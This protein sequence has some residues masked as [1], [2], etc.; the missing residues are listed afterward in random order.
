MKMHLIVPS[1]CSLQPSSPSFAVCTSTTIVCVCVEIKT[2]PRQTY[3]LCV[4]STSP[5]VIVQSTET[6]F[7]QPE[8]IPKTQWSVWAFSQA[9]SL[10]ASPD[11][12]GL[13]Q[14]LNS[15]W[16]CSFGSQCWESRSGQD[17]HL[18]AGRSPRGCFCLCG[19]RVSG[20]VAAHFQERFHWC[21]CTS[22]ILAN[23]QI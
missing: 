10:H 9:R 13:F 15:W 18:P 5:P 8:I 12:Y 14:T 22:T 3:K 4:L 19:P 7:H 23:A 20:G 6:S 17:T 11:F 16:C 1:H 2:Q 21:S